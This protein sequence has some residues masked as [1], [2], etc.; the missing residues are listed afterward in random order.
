MYNALSYLDWKDAVY[1]KHVYR[2]F[3][4]KPGISGLWF[5]GGEGGRF[6]E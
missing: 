5:V 6:R 3:Q 4:K 1:N 2:I